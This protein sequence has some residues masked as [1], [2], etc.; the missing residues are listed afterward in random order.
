[1]YSSEALLKCFKP[2]LIFEGCQLHSHFVSDRLTSLNYLII[3]GELKLTPQNTFMENQTLTL[4][5]VSAR[6]LPLGQR[7]FGKGKVP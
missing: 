2:S 4:N 5:N 6:I 3:E 1:M 7:P